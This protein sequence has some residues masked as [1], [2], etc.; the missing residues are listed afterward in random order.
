MNSCVCKSLRRPTPTYATPRLA[1]VMCLL[2]L[3]ACLQKAT[4]QTVAVKTNP[5]YWATTSLNAAAEV[6]LSPKWTAELSLGYNPFDFLPD[7]KKLKHALVQTEGRYWLCSA[8]A[9]H[10]VGANLLYSHYNAGGVNL[11]F[12]S[13]LKDHRFQGD[14]GAVG[15]VY[16]Y[17]MPL[18]RRWS[19]EGVVGLGYGIT[20]YRKYS[21]ETCGAYK[22]TETKHLLMPTKL[23]VSFIYYL[24]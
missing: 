3:F 21:C 11:P 23:S 24:D 10:F 17:S 22:T 15:V 9:G 1:T 13:E 4:A 14:L 18:S 16:G 12:F 19:V 8:F 2:L 6:R 5:L 20:R 7:N